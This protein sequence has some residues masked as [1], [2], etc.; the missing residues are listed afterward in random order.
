MRSATGI[1]IPVYI[2]PGAEAAQRVA[3]LTDT[4]AACCAQVEDPSTSAPQAD[5]VA[6]GAAV[7]EQLATDW[8]VTY[9]ATPVNRGKLQVSGRGWRR[10][11]AG[12]T[13]PTWPS[14]TATAIT[15]ATSP[16]LRQSRRTHRGAD[17]RCTG[18]DPGRRLSRHRWAG[19][20][21]KLEEI[22]DRMLLHALEYHAAI[23]GTPLRLEYATLIEAIPD[24]HSGYKLFSRRTAQDVFSSHRPNLRG[25]RRQPT[26]ATPSRR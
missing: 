17:R 20:A 2:P 25:S 23:S 26:S 21:V 9:T 16:E 18:A 24:F 13:S 15:S 7:V 8:G 3:L 4:V 14:S 12:R 10:C 6:N 11:C 19:C 5:G 22:A 1:V